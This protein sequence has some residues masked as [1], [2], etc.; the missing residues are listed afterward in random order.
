M[1]SVMS[2]RVCFSPQTHRPA[3]WTPLL[4]FAFRAL[5]V[6]ATVEPSLA[7]D[8][9]ITALAMHQPT[10]QLII[11]SQSGLHVVALPESGPQSSGRLDSLDWK[12]IATAWSTQ[13]EAIHD[14]AISPDGAVF[15]V[16]GGTPGQFGLVEIVRAA[17]GERLLT[18]SD[19][20]DTVTSVAFAHDGSLLAT[21]GS[22]G[23]VF[24]Y[25]LASV[26]DSPAD[27]RGMPL[28]AERLFRYSGRTEPVTAV[29]L[30]RA[31][32]HTWIVSAGLDHTIQLCRPTGDGSA[33]LVRTLNNHT[34]SVGSL[35]LQTHVVST[36]PNSPAE[37]TLLAS[38]ADDRTVRFWHPHTGRLLRFARLDVAPV[39][40]VLT[41]DGSRAYVGDAAG[42][43]LTIESATARIRES[44]ATGLSPI[45]SLALDASHSRL[46][47]GGPDGQV[48][49]RQ[50]GTDGAP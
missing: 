26:D 6:I 25:R 8:P 5:L 4:H 30:M 36:A 13:L 23:D 48:R 38:A 42:N 37:T 21:G 27:Q 32:D 28:T 17:D 2:R 33:E 15:A 39:V 14:I 40:V 20:Q 29:G 9:P 1:K 43:I 41:E 10:G 7:A 12:P 3:T 35:S 18:L 34:A 31:D 22:D 11:G 49:I 47:A 44:V 46:F 50:L 19:H 16:A 24:G 45:V